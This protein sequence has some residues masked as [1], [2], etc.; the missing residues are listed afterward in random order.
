MEVIVA[1][2]A[3]LDVHKDTV[4]ACVRVPGTGGG[5]RQEVREFRTFTHDL[6]RLRAW[7]IDQAVTH[8]AMEA[9]GVYWRPACTGDRYGTCSRISRASSC[10]S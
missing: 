10:C 7:L 3:G 1:R 4:T 8:I 9:T 2:A 5:R 6:R